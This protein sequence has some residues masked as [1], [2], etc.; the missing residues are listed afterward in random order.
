MT[1]LQGGVR[2]LGKPFLDYRLHAEIL[3]RIERSI[4][5]AIVRGDKQS[6]VKL[7]EDGGLISY[8]GQAQKKNREREEFEEKLRRFGIRPPW[9]T[10]GTNTLSE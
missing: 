5:E 2:L 7:A 6:A 3:S 9:I 10:E 4:V 1:S 8:G